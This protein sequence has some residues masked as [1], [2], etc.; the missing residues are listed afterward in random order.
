M[1]RRTLIV[2]LLVNLMLSACAPAS[3]PTPTPAPS[4]TPLPITTPTSRPTPTATLTL[5]PSPTSTGPPY[6][7]LG[8]LTWY[9]PRDFAARLSEKTSGQVAISDTHRTALL[10]FLSARQYVEVTAGSYLGDSPQVVADRDRLAQ[11]RANAGFR[12]LGIWGSSG[13]E[14]YNLTF[15][16]TGPNSPWPFVPEWFVQEIVQPLRVAVHEGETVLPIDRRDLDA[17]CLE[18]DTGY[19]NDQV[20]IMDPDPAKREAVMLK[21]STWDRSADSIRL[22]TNPDL[23]SPYDFGAFKFDHAA[24]TPVRLNVWH[25]WGNWWGYNMTNVGPTGPAGTPY[26]GLRWNQYRPHI[27]HR[28]FKQIRDSQGRL[29]FDGVLLDTFNQEW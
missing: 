11:A 5:T 23:R 25:D 2:F 20:I 6:P 27:I 4:A 13:N 21:C 7:R 9:T 12:L 18:R 14:P 29:L 1:M 10:D 15:N 17:Y 24:G 3:A 8:I 16:N 26:E 19:E 22:T 28:Q